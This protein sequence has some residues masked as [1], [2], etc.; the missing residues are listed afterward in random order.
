M[1]DLWSDEAAVKE[2]IAESLTLT[3][4]RQ[5]ALDW[6][7]AKNDYGA[8]VDLAEAWFC[9]VAVLDGTYDYLHDEAN[10]R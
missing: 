7:K 2:L 8:A 5:E 1:L 9:L 4:E 6:I 10:K 3:P